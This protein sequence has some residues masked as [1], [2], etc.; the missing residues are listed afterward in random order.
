MSNLK[1][2]E[3]TL[4][5]VLQAQLKAAN[6]TYTNPFD[7]SK[8]YIEDLTRDECLDKDGDKL[9]RL[10]GLQR[11]AH[12]NRGGVKRMTSDIKHT[13]ARDNPI[14]AVTVQYEFKD[15]TIFS[16]SADATTKAHKQPYNLHLVAVAESKAEAR[17]LRRA[18]NIR[19]VSAEEI[20]SA[21]IAGNDN[22]PIEDTQVSG[23][24]LIG[25]RKGLTEPDILKLI[26]RTD[27][28]SLTDLTAEEGR[29]AMKAINRLRKK[30]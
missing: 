29:T 2:L 10:K 23:I 8:N 16:G 22:G 21:P 20:G 9:P 24:M 11:L 28:G 5:T 7:V 6:P 14:A 1:Q 19:T 18:F 4:T 13:P 26:K 3:E 15:G 12:T 27:V 17:A 30:K 25:K